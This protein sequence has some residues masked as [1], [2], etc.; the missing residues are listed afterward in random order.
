MGFVEGVAGKGNHLF[1]NG[2]RCFPADAVC[3]A[4][5]HTVFLGPMDEDFLLPVHDLFFLFAH[6]PAD[7]VAAAIA[8]ARQ[9]THN[10]HHLFLVYH[11]A[12]GDA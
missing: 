4:A 2:L 9:V 12:V 11:T 7:L 5:G 8:E 3:Q 1:I 10:L 6:R